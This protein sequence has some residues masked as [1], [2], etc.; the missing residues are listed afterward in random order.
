VIEDGSRGTTISAESRWGMLSV[1]PSKP[2][3]TGEWKE[4]GG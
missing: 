1:T 2:S 4:N 3:A